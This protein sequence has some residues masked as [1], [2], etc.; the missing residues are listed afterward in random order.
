MKKFNL[1]ALALGAFMMAA[2]GGGGGDSAEGGDDDVSGGI[3]DGAKDKEKDKEKDDASKKDDEV[4]KE[5]QKE[6]D[7]AMTFVLLNGLDINLKTGKKK[8]TV[9]GE[10]HWKDIDV[11]DDMR[12]SDGT[13]EMEGYKSKVYVVKT[14]YY[15]IMHD[16]DE[17]IVMNN[18]PYKP[19]KHDKVLSYFGSAFKATQRYTLFGD[20]FY[21]VDMEKKTGE[22]TIT[23]IEPRA[24]PGGVASLTSIK[25]IQKDLEEIYTGGKYVLKSTGGVNDKGEQSGVFSFEDSKG[26]VT[27]KD[28]KYK[29]FLSGPKGE[30]IMGWL[31]TNDDSAYSDP[32]G[33]ISVFGARPVS[34][35]MKM[36]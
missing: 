22:G 28:K 2:C 25:K 21:K 14:D 30:Q 29:V 23:K 36:K 1:L 34:S 17:I 27:M 10:V 35:V 19:T 12:T 31:R 18:Y 13:A 9:N 20:F 33:D 3:H 11:D 6:I 26:N 5:I 16:E 24:I 4:T 7:E 8:M 15:G 32:Y